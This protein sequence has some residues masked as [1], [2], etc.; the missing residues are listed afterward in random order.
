MEKILRDYTTKPSTKSFWGP[1]LA[2]EIGLKKI[3]SKCPRFNAW[4][5]KLENI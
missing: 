1:M 3:R 5:D 2:Q 4:I